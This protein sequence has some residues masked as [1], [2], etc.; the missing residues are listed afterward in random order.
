VQEPAD[1][2]PDVIPAGEVA[3]RHVARGGW[4]RALIGFA[5]GVAAGLLAA[6]VVPRDEGPVRRLTPDD[7]PD[8]FPET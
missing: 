7:R 6:L 1:E 5:L 3:R 2:A 8:P 4:Q